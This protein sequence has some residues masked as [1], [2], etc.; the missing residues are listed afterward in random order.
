[1]P[2]FPTTSYN[3]LQAKCKETSIIK[4][5]KKV[6]FVNLKNTSVF[7][8]AG[9]LNDLKLHFPDLIHNLSLWCS[10]KGIRWCKHTFLSLIT[11][12]WYVLRTLCVCV[13]ICDIYVLEIKTLVKKMKMNCNGVLYRN[14]KKNRWMLKNLSAE[15][16]LW[17]RVW[18]TVWVCDY[19]TAGAT[20]WVALDISLT[21][22]F[23]I[24]WFSFINV[25][26]NITTITFT[27]ATSNE[28]AT[29]NSV[30]DTFCSF[31]L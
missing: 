15:E 9:C 19:D 5:L 10:L 23:N 31:R 27:K 18:E 3:L 7:P 13:F 8:P 25:L 17:V 4:L 29:H 14:F 6:S 28:V 30:S 26:T 21:N 1:M 2:V 11:L 12:Y 24:I 20:M 16:S 22:L